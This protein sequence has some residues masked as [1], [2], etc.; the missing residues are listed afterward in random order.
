MN[1][2][3]AALLAADIALAERD[4][5]LAA[6]ESRRWPP[7]LSYG[8]LPDAV[9]GARTASNSIAAAIR[10]FA[11]TLPDDA[12]ERREVA[13]RL[14]KLV[15]IGPLDLPDSAWNTMHKAAALLDPEGK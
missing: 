14:R 8:P 3:E 6:H 10:A 12:A 15:H 13:Q 9:E 5:W 11:A 4:G 1:A 2:R 7:L